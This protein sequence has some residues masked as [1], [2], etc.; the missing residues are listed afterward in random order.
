MLQ[1]QNI[2]KSFNNIVTTKNLDIDLHKNTITTLIKPNN[3]NKTT[4]FNL[5]TNFITPNQKSIIL[6]NTKLINHTPNAITQLKLIHSFQNIQLIQQI[7][8]LQNMMITIQK[9]PNKHIIPLFTKKSRARKNKNKTH[10][11]TIS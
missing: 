11:K 7:S 9:Q 6:N 5:L 3:T 4:I 10:E 1:T 2:S 8:Y